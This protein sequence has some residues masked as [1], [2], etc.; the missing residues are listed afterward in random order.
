MRRSSRLALALC[1]LLSS[2]TALLATNDEGRNVIALAAAV[3]LA[4]VSSF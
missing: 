2:S 1:V 3:A 4:G